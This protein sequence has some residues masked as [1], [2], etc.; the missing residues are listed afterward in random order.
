MNIGD[1]A[2][3][4]H[5]CH[6]GGTNVSIGE[7]TFINYNCV[8]DNNAAIEIG[9]DCAVAMNVLV[10]TSGHEVGPSERRV[11]ALES[12]PVVIGDGCWIG[13]GAAI[14]LGVTIGPGSIVAA[15]SVVTRDVERDS[16]VGGA[17]AKAISHLP[18]SE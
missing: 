15:G 9:D 18:T 12:G 14:L 13:A 17:P 3:I 11:G 1:G 10:V 2:V 16:L 8:F 6:F 4:F 7:R 5:G